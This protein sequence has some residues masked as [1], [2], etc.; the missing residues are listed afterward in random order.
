MKLADIILGNAVVMLLFSWFFFCFRDSILIGILSIYGY[1]ICTS[2]HRIHA[3]YTLI[4]HYFSAVF[5]IFCIFLVQFTVFRVLL[6]QKYLDN[7]N[8]IYTLTPRDAEI[9]N[10][11]ETFFMNQMRV[12]HD[13]VSS[14]ISDFQIDDLT[15]EVGE[16][17]EAN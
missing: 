1:N 15:F 10:I 6:H 4:L 3:E 12:R 17:T 5:A 7:T 14:S 11:R 8:L 9:G 16:E 13:I 2:M